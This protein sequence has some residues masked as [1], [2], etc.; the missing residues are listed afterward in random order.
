MAE[1]PDR[2]D[3]RETGAGDRRERIAVAAYYNAERRGFGSSG[4]VDDWLEAER[5]IDDRASEK[6]TRGEAAAQQPDGGAGP[7]VTSPGNDA[8]RPD[9]PDL[10][11]AGI[12]HVEPDEVDKW[13]RRL[14]VPAP[15][16]REAMQRVGPVIS[17]IKR[18]LGGA[19][20]PR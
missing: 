7:S 2:K 9:F 5:Q 14:K 1:K 3:G 4:E 20:A 17:D 12:P 19:S 10:D 6:G 13:A 18:F 11:R 8:D 15:R 16:L